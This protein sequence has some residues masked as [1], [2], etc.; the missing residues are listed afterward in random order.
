MMKAPILLLWAVFFLARAEAQLQFERE[1]R[2]YVWVLGASP[3][4]NGGPYDAIRMD[5]N[6]DEQLFEGVDL[7]MRFYLANTSM[8]SR[9]G[10]LLFYTNGIEIRNYNN[11]TLATNLA[12]TPLS[13]GWLHTGYPLSQGVLALPQPGTDSIYYVFHED[14]DWAPYG[15]VWVRRLYYT[16]VDMGARQGQGEVIERDIPIIDDTLAYGRVVATRHANGRDWW[17]VVPELDNNA[18]YSILFT[19]RGI[20]EI[21]NFEIG[22]T[23]LTGISQS[24]FSP[25]GTKYA[26]IDVTLVGDSEHQVSLYDF[27]RCTGLLTS[28]TTFSFEDTGFVS[29]GL[30]F[31][32]NGRFLYPVAWLN[33]YQYDLWAADIAASKVKVL[34]YD[35][36]E[37][38]SS[39]HLAQLA[40]DGK[41]YIGSTGTGHFLNVIHKPNQKGAACEAEIR[42]IDL[43]VINDGSMAHHPYYGLGP[44]DGSP[45]DTLGIDNPPPEAAFSYVIE[46]SAAFQVA[47]YDGTRFSPESWYWEFG[48]GQ[49]STERFP[50]HTYSS[51]GAY[52]ACLSASNQSGSQTVCDTVSLLINGLGPVGGEEAG[53]RVFPNPASGELFV[54]GYCS[55]IDVINQLGQPVWRRSLPEGEFRHLIDL[56]GLPG[57]VYFLRAW[58]KNALVY[59]ARL[60]ISR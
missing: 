49:S 47:F 2:D 46:D 10:D 58:L 12:P 52:Q 11:D 55:R 8:C 35:Y 45:C 59:Q 23:V 20:E 51:P 25:D 54:E 34:E 16:K 28:F 3:I 38:N 41:I 9:Q 48:D 33:I 31:S 27:D 4:E 1:K 19:P 24:R 36:L 18:Y 29:G 6:N 43:P 57:G 30:A 50:I 17:V 44:I 40:P 56:Q 60:I 26:R 13:Q 39:F 22:D 53:L 21:K 15:G 14:V 32:G 37:E 42:A 7:D 5:F